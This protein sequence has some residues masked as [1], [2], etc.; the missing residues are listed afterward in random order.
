MRREGPGMDMLTMTVAMPVGA[1]QSTVRPVAV[2]QAQSEGRSFATSLNEGIELVAGTEVKATTDQ[3]AAE[4]LGPGK[5]IDLD[6]EQAGA[7]LSTARGKAISSSTARPDQKAVAMLLQKRAVAADRTSIRDG[8]DRLHMAAAF[9]L[10]T[11]DSGGVKNFAAKTD[12]AAVA[13][14][15]ELDSETIAGSAGSE[16]AEEPVG[17][18]GARLG[19]GR[20]SLRSHLSR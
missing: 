6:G 9:A 1:E 18:H 8:S 3:G 16:Q 12:D 2:E 14:L 5:R 19:R 4:L 17:Q 15:S 13:A 10:Q 20:D 11:I 7:T